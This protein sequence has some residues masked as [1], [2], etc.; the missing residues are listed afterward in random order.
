MSLPCVLCPVS[1]ALHQEEHE[2]VAQLV[3]HVHGV[4]AT[5]PDG[6]FE[7]PPTII[8]GVAV[9]D[10]STQQQQLIERIN[11]AFVKV[12][13]DADCCTVAHILT[14]KI[15][16]QASSFVACMLTVLYC[17]VLYCT[18]SLV[19][20]GFHREA[21]HAAEEARC[22]N[23]VLS[24]GRLG[25]GQGGRGPGGDQR[26]EA[27]PHGSASRVLGEGVA[28]PCL[29][30]CVRLVSCCVQCAAMCMFCSALRN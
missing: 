19:R 28:W 21:T 29:D 25:A 26:A 27:A 12:C 24:V 8:R 3:Q 5:A 1:L 9:S 13:F 14:L 10:L 2:I 6:L 11:A 20:A 22:D 18:G 17:T 15:A 16:M 30:V 7:D 23:S 4:L